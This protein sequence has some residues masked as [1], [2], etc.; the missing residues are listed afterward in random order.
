[1]NQESLGNSQDNQGSQQRRTGR[2]SGKNPKPAKQEEQTCSG[3][4]EILWKPI[5]LDRK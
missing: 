4:C 5:K 2:A 3:T 1:M